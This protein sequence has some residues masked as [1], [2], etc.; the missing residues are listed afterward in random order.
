MYFEKFR[1]NL[2]VLNGNGNLSRVE[3]AKEIGILN[4]ARLVSLEYGRGNPTMEEMISIS[5]YYKISFDDLL[6]K[7]AKIIFE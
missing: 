6:N 5:A 7:T 3:L 4:G 2:R 1:T